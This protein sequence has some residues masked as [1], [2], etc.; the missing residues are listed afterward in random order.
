M[1][2]AWRASEG[3]EGRSSVRSWLYRIATN[4]C[5]DL[6]RGRR[7][8]AQPMELGPSRPPVEPSLEAL[9]PEGSWVSP[10]ADERALPPEPDPAELAV[11]RASIR[12]PF[13]AARQHLPPRQRP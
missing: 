6:L 11:A 5:L 7:R 2:R 13:T 9:L 8:R 4:V 3:F 12:L 10:I 1:L